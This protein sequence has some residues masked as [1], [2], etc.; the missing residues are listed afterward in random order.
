M[1]ERQ[2]RED[3]ET[4]PLG[5][6]EVFQMSKVVSTRL[7]DDDHSHFIK[8]VERLKM[9]NTEVLERLVAIFNDTYDCLHVVDTIS[10]DDRY[11]IAREKVDALIRHL[12]GEK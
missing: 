2:I 10:F 7:S 11:E 6:K 12:E 3:V 4:G 5:K 1:G 8:I 9:S